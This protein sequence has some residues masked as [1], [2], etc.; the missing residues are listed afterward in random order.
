[1]TDLFHVQARARNLNIYLVE[2]PWK[3]RR[4]I[5][6]FVSVA[7]ISTDYSVIET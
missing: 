5:D 1:V 6:S 7:T 4:G 3:F 2:C